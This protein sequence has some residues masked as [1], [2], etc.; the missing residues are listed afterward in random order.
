MN[1]GQTGFIKFQASINPQEERLAVGIKPQKLTIGIPKETNPNENRIALTPLAVDTLVSMGHE[2]RVES[3]SGN[4]ANFPDNDFSE[5]GA[6][7]CSTQAEVFQSDIIL[8]VSPCNPEEVDLLKGNQLLISAINIGILSKSYLIALMKKK[9][10]AIGYELIRDINGH[11][12]VVAS[13]SEII[14]STTILKAAE[15]LSDAK[16]GKGKILGGISGVNPSEVV[17]LGAGTTAEYAARIALGLGAV[18]KVFDHSVVKLNQLQRNINQR[19]FTSII[20]AHI[21]SKALITADIVIG[22]ID[23]IGENSRFLVTEDMVKQMKKGSVIID[24]SIDQGGCVETSEVTSHDQPIFIKHGIVHY[25]VPNIPST[26]ARTASYAL[27]NIFTP[28]II[29]IGEASSLS[30]LIQYDVEIRNGIYVYKGLLTNMQI[31]K[32]FDLP[33][34]DIDILSA[35]L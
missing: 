24:T 15:F 9:V 18:V 2:V 6:F 19:I 25:C 20:Q 17:I 35:L 32:Y 12:P 13:M 27:S 31:G 33:V 7:I 8:K 21:L 28:L 4:Q 34:K 1:K 11:Y 14:G 10:T 5:M 30:Q 26:V 23:A 3:G 29:R 16:I 22:A